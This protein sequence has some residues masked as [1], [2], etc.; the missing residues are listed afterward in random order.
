LLA[1]PILWLAGMLKG[2]PGMDV[3]HAVMILSSLFL[4]GL[5]VLIFLPETKGQPLPD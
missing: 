1:A 4:A 5:V 3:R 2:L